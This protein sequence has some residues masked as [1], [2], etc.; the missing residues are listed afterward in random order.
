MK[1][2]RYLETDQDPFA[3]YLD[4]MEDIDRNLAEFAA[5][6][7]LVSGDSGVI[8]YTI[9]SG[10]TYDYQETIGND[11]SSATVPV[12]LEITF[13]GDQSQQFP[14][15]CPS[16]TIWCNGTGSGNVLRP[17]QIWWTDS[18]SR[19]VLLSYPLKLVVSSLSSPYSRRWRV[20]LDVYRQVTL[21]TK[22]ILQGT[23]RGSYT[24]VRVS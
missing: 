3:K 18:S 12:V 2:L 13:T 4:I 6:R 19:Y 21:R 23:C 10:A 9:N 11:S 16:M 17:D 1:D 22:A 5:S 24:V 20:N 8:G 15:L 14:F 7:Q